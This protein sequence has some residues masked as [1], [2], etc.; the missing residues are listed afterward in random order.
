MSRFCLP[1]LALGC[2]IGLIAA[3]SLPAAL[4][5]LGQLAQ[6]SLQQLS[7]GA[8]HVT[9][10]LN[11]YAAISLLTSQPSLLYDPSSVDL[12][13]RQ[14][15]SG[16]SANLPFLSAPAAAI[17]LAPLGA[18]DYGHAYALWL[19]LNCACLVASV[20]LLAPGRRGLW[21]LGLP[22]VLPAQFG[23]IMGQSAPLALLAFCLFVR[24]SAHPRW[25]GLILG[26][27]P[28][29]WKPQF[30]ASLLPALA[31]ARRWSS[32]A[33][34]LAAP[35]A[36]AALALAL[37][38]PR[39]IADYRAQ[40]VENWHLVSSRVAYQQS[41]ESLLGVF[42]VLGQPGP[43]ADSLYIVSG[44]AIEAVL[45]WLWW[46]GLRTDSARYLQLAALPIAAVLVAPHA[47]VYEL[48]T[49][50]AS[51]W[52]LLAY[53]ERRPACRPAVV[54]L[55]LVGWAAANVVTVT[56]RE[57]SFP[58]AAIVGLA[59][60]GLIAWLLGSHASAPRPITATPRA[61]AAA[62]AFWRPLKNVSRL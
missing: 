8:A 59:A 12:L 16:A 47:L 61:P 20:L 43:L 2:A 7:G 62:G 18:L 36:F 4:V 60:L 33:W 40:S 6:V 44:L 23:L 50:L 52:L 39:L 56:E 19:A 11:L 29:A 30:L 48:T 28:F 13:Q 1:T 54:G 17:S 31:A 25:S 49:W 35:L 58:Y 57:L 24:L 14:L 38:G 21:L 9:D 53:A 34:A 42:Q 27:S 15:S 3:P 26:L 37:G 45:V 22:L 51:A 55:C 5:G 32:L 41:G 46:R 10:F